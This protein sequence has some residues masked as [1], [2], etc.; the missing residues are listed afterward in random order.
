MIIV[1]KALAQRQHAE[2]PVRVAMIG[3]GF[4]AR[5]IALQILNYVPGMDLVAISNRSL[6]GAMRAYAEAG[7][8][9]VE[10]VE[11]VAQLDK[12]ISAGRYA[13]TEEA[14][15]L[16]R[17]GMVDAVI[18]VT[19]TVEFGAHVVLEAIT[20]G[21]H[22]IVMNAELDGT[23]GPILK[24]KADESGVV[25]TNADGDQPGVIMNLYRFVRG[26]GS[27]RY[28]VATSK[29]CRIP[30]RNPTTQAEFAR[31][32]KQKPHICLLYTS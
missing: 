31:K 17:A 21:K 1:D 25:F 8:P 12:A 32:W 26:I 10:V 4:M 23:I 30:Y 24:Y 19:G 14:M 2:N 3:A 16:C 22:V 15:L 28:F 18:E 11:S 6:P 5:G 9:D 27:S 13:V 7:Q 20:H 29:A